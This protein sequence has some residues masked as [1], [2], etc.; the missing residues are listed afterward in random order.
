[1]SCTGDGGG[2]KAS[3][4][5]AFY[6]ESSGRLDSSQNVEDSGPGMG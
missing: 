6:P 1:M 4:R 2:G 5:M 3:E